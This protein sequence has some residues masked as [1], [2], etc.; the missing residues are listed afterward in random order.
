MGLQDRREIDVVEHVTID[1]DDWTLR[2]KAP[3]GHQTPSRSEDL[4]VFAGVMEPAPVEPSVGPGIEHRLQ[5][6]AEMVCVYNDIGQPE[7]TKA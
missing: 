5:T 3:G 4:L 1:S 7:G 6:A 2:K